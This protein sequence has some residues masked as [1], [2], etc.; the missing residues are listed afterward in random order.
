MKCHL[1]RYGNIQP[2]T[3]ESLTYCP[4][5]KYLACTREEGVVEIYSTTR[6][7]LLQRYPLSPIK[8]SCKS[9]CWD[10]EILYVGGSAKKVWGIK[11]SEGRIVTTLNISAKVTCL[12]FN[13]YL[14]VGT[15][16]SAVEFYS[17]SEHDS[18]SLWSEGLL[19]HS[20]GRTTCI[21]VLGDSVFV[22]T[23]EGLVFGWV[24]KGKSFELV[25][26]V[27][28]TD[29]I[30]EAKYNLSRHE[31][32]FSLPEQEDI[33]KEQWDYV[34]VPQRY[35][36]VCALKLIDAMTVAVGSSHGKIQIWDIMS[37]TIIAEFKE[38]Q[39][40]VLC[41]ALSGTTL[42]ASGVDHKIVEFKECD[43]RWKSRKRVRY[44]THTV[45]SLAV[46]QHH[47]VSGG[48]DTTFFV[49]DNKNIDSIIL[50]RFPFG[51]T[52]SAVHICPVARIVVMLEKPNVI[53]FYTLQPSEPF[54]DHSSEIKS[55][56][57]DLLYQIVLAK[58]CQVNCFTVNTTCSQL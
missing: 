21:D 38:H 57:Y 44:H 46:N 2:S 3:I 15:E 20:K 26:T 35:T 28:S 5:G 52:N 27:Y 54:S 50:R 41:F 16:K 36:P 51:R 4:T 30:R 19:N 43:G 49:L 8:G 34:E 39:A 32:N 45:K 42:Y 6:Y 10:G 33:K 40:D 1:T 12:S 9:S 24:K 17:K 37:M 29:P 23:S 22:G 7:T 14:F 58:D 11:V 53:S 13:G 18:T 55:A 31:L 25:F 56:D 47:L 48:V